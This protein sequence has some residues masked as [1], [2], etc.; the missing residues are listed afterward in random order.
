MIG[1]Q[2]QAVLPLLGNYKI[3]QRSSMLKRTSTNLTGAVW[4]AV[5]SL[6]RCEAVYFLLTSEAN[7]VLTVYKWLTI[8][9]T[10]VRWIS[11]LLIS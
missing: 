11:F 6:G 4:L 2:V 10:N 5:G 9:F 1:T 7:N 3:M 8:S